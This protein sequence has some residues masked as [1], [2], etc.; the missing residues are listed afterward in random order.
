MKVKDEKT[1]KK[2]AIHIYICLILSHV[3]MFIVGPRL[4]LLT[5]QWD[6]GSFE[7][8]VVG[9]TFFLQYGEFWGSDFI[10]V[11]WYYEWYIAKNQ[12]DN[13]KYSYLFNT[14]ITWCHAYCSTM[15]SA[16]VAFII[17]LHRAKANVSS[18]ATI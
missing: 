16:L 4:G 2:I 14:N 13:T 7:A 17:S 11:R 15:K 18:S 10:L 9:S 3:I 12:I 1:I 5:T 8:M 6:I